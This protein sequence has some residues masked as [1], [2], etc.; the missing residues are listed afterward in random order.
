[1][2]GVSAK[3]LAV[4]QRLS[5]ACAAKIALARGTVGKRQ[6]PSRQSHM[7]TCQ[8]VGV[9]LAAQLAR[10][11]SPLGFAGSA[12]ALAA[13]TVLSTISPATAPA[14]C[15]AWALQP[16]AEKLNKARA[17]VESTVPPSGCCAHLV[18]LPLR[19]SDLRGGVEERALRV[20]YPQHL[21]N[22]SALVRC[23]SLEALAAGHTSDTVDPAPC[24]TRGRSALMALV[25][26]VE[27]YLTA[28]EEAT[29]VRATSC[30][31]HAPHTDLTV[32]AHSSWRVVANSRLLCPFRT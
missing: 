29:E 23:C 7:A 19:A 16:A 31:L 21:Q 27:R 8:P 3:D 17:S 10:T 14:S 2:G 9:V 11:S 25:P 26:V 4:R 28:L 18:A 15:D 1:V 12:C 22:G 32:P 30:A 24:F 5:L 20:C 6:L 13:A